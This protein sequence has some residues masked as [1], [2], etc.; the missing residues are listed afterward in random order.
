[1]MSDKERIEELEDALRDMLGI[2][3]DPQYQHHNDR[4]AIENAEQVLNRAKQ[5]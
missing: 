2:V 4:P 1:M 3:G 5:T